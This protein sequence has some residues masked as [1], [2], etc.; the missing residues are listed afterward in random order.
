M[1]NNQPLADI[2]RPSQLNDY[3]GQ[4]HILGPGKIL[5]QMLKHQSLRT[6]SS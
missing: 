6:L 1:G 3:V 2:L 4:E 5:E